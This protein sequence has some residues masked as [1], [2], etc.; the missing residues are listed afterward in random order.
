MP[1]EPAPITNK[2]KSYVIKLNSSSTTDVHQFINVSMYQ[3]VVTNRSNGFG[4][5]IGCKQFF[6]GNVRDS[7]QWGTPD[8]F[9]LSLN[10]QS[11]GRLEIGLQFLGTA[12]ELTID[13]DLRGRS[14]ACHGFQGCGRGIATDD[15]FFVLPAFILQERFRFGTEGT[16]H[17]R[18][19]GD[20]LG[21]GLGV[22]IAQHGFSV[23][24]FEGIS[25]FF[26]LDEH[27]VDH[28][29]FD[30]HGVTPGAFTEAEVSFVHQHPHSFGEI[31]VTIG[32]QGDIVTFLVFGPF[33]HDEG[34]VNRE[35]DNFVYT[36][37]FEDAGKLVVAGE[38]AGGA[39]GG[40]GTGEGEDHH[41]SAVEDVFAVNVFPFPILTG[42]EDNLGNSLSGF[43][44]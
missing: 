1:P 6:K 35:T 27:F 26:R 38:V 18:E 10:T 14:L 29:I 4:Y 39:G 11:L 30:V 31:T 15:D 42:A 36:V 21:L 44:L 8:P 9:R 32:N 13:E 7:H 20:V 25:G 40:E 41:V 17:F 33:V 22:D 16:S 23:G 3:W 37:G 28:A 24:D 2:S 34:V 12:D 43:V 19:Q 5:P